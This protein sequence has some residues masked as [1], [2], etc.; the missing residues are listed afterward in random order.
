M[1]LWKE[2]AI[3]PSL[4]A[5]YHLGDAILSGMGIEHGRIIAGV[6]P[7]GAASCVGNP[8]EASTVRAQPPTWLPR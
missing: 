8:T 1:P 2:C 4:F 5:N 7:G 3:E 6:V